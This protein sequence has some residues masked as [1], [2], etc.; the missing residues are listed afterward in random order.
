MREFSAT[1]GIAAT[2]EAAFDFVADYRN[3]PAVLEGISRWQPL[4]RRH[5]GTGARFEV[6]MVT[7][8]VPM[9]NVLVL[10]AWERPRGLGWH[11]ESGLIEQRGGWRFVPAR[12]GV[13]VTLWISYRPPGAALGNLIAARADGV[14][15]RR[16]ERALA[17]M[18]DRLET[19][20]G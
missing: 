3:V 9:G 16:L 2:P 4:G 7:F 12:D 20:S 14:V 17:A 11:S 15:R 19:E 5:V 8:G 18:R 10:D 1:V 13:E 6:E